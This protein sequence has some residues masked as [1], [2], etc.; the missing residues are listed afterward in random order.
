MYIE[1]FSHKA[2]INPCSRYV[3][4]LYE[5]KNVVLVELSVNINTVRKVYTGSVTVITN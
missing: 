5:G 4:F 1:Q 3:T 2:A